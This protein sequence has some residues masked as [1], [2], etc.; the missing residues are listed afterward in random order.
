MSFSSYPLTF[1]FPWH[2]TPA[3]IEQL[4]LYEMLQKNKPTR[5]SLPIANFGK[6][7]MNKITI[8]LLPFVVI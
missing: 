7:A 2:Q 6:I 8:A 4:K 1:L 3:F 5:L